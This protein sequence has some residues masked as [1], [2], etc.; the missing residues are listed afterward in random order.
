LEE[1]LQSIHPLLAGE[2][3]ILT[4]RDIS[5]KRK[6]RL[7]LNLSRMVINPPG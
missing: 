5:D 3:Y 1:S 6:S 4:A 7:Q 2:S